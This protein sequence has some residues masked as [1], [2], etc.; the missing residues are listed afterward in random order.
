MNLIVL[1][2]P[3]QSA[4]EAWPYIGNT[5]AQIDAEDV[6]GVRKSIVVDRGDVDLVGEGWACKAPGLG[7]AIEPFTDDH[8][9][10]NKWAYWRCLELAAAAGGDLILLEDDLSF[11]RNAVRRM[12]LFP[13][14]SDLGLVSFF[15][16]RILET[17]SAIPGL[18]R[19]P[20]FT[21]FTQAIKF[22]ESCLLRLVAWKNDRRWQQYTASDNALMVAL[23]N[24]G[25]RYGVHCPDL[26]QHTGDISE[27][28]PLCDQVSEQRVSKMWPGPGFDALSLFA[29]DE[30]YR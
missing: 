4:P 16:P 5:L 1:T 3:R 13:V 15:S 22:S 9:V 7:W 8:L 23:T 19:P 12:M 30:L 6:A 25:I 26:V 11:C 14:P 18:W 29:H 24:L 27:C 20:R 28:T 17:A 2:C 10:G 21:Y